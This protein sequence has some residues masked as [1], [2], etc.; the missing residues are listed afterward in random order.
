MSTSP[1]PTCADDCE[2]VLRL[3]ADAPPDGLSMDEIQVA[4]TWSRHYVNSILCDLASRVRNTSVRG[5]SGKKIVKYT[6]KQA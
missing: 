3:I 4:T 5:K 6:L 2:I 1:K